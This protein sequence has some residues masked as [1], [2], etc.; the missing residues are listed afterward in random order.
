MMST[1]DNLIVKL[2]NE[3]WLENNNQTIAMTVKNSQ[4]KNKN[5]RQNDFKLRKEK[6]EK[7]THCDKPNHTEKN[8]YIK[9]PEKR[10]KKDFKDSGNRKQE[11]PL[12]S[13]KTDSKN[14]SKSDFSLTAV[15]AAAAIMKDIWL[16]D[17]ET[18]RHICKN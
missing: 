3:E 12:Y 1:L 9:Y 8:C 11:K 15:Y 10:P 13:L 5:N 2:I 6:E 14:D 4:S 18:S 7:Y 17:S 16:A